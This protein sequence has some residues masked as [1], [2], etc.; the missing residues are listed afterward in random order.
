MVA[1]LCICKILGPYLGLNT[2]C[3]VCEFWWFC[4]VSLGKCCNFVC[5]HII[6]SALFTV[7]IVC[8]FLA[9]KSIVKLKKIN[10]QIC[11]IDNIMHLRKSFNVIWLWP[12][13]ASACIV[14][15][16]FLWFEWLVDLNMMH[17]TKH[18]GMKIVDWLWGHFQYSHIK[19]CLSAVLMCGSVDLTLFLLSS[20]ILFENIIIHSLFCVC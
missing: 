5:F 11:K 18:H 16:D 4:I 14:G 10:V 7:S 12:L 13:T 8:I 15:V 17:L 2:F 6:S 9:V 20:H 3:C 19:E 1:F